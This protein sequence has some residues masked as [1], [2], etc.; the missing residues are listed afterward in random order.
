[1]FKNIIIIAGVV[2]IMLWVFTALMDS[3][4]AAN[5]V[6]DAGATDNTC[7]LYTSPSPRD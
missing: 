3:A 7:L 1:M 4:M 5:D 2:A 6:N